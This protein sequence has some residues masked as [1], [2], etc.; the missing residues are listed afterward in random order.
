MPGIKHLVECHCQLRIYRDLKKTIYHKFPVYSRID[1][2][3]KIIKKIVKCNNCE[4]VHNVY[5]INRSEIFINK[6]ETNVIKTKEDISF[7]LPLGI[8]RIMESNFATLADY[9][10][11]LDIIENKSWG[12]IIVIKREIINEIHHVKYLKINSKDNFVIKN[13]TINDIVMPGEI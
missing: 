7:S 3:N 1:E 5:D 10:H 13:E 8:V 2:N 9:E 4:T 6:E 11:A 12:G